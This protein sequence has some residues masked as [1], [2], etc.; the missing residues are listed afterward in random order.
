[1]FNRSGYKINFIAIIKFL[2]GGTELDDISS[3]DE[4]NEEFDVDD[5]LV[6]ANFIC[7]EPEC[8]HTPERK[9]CNL[10]IPNHSDPNIKIPPHTKRYKKN[11]SNQ[12]ADVNTLVRSGGAARGIITNVLHRIPFLPSKVSPQSRKN[13]QRR[14]QDNWSLTSV[15]KRA[16]STFDACCCLPI[17]NF[18]GKWRFTRDFEWYS[19]TKYDHRLFAI[20]NR[21]RNR[22]LVAYS[23]PSEVMWKC[24]PSVII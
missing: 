22:H 12:K 18:F 5:E 23:Y 8:D 9:N 20:G 13:G 21:V 24:L 11:Q 16:Q 6:S 10:N 17:S 1:M 3:G 15:F 19:T 2:G 4:D 7:D 14:S